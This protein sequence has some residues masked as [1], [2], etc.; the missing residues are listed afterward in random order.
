MPTNPPTQ[1]DPDQSVAE[2]QIREVF[3]KLNGSGAHA[4]YCERS[5]DGGCTCALKDEYVDEAVA[6]LKALLLDAQ[7]KTLEDFRLFVFG[8]HY[9]GTWDGRGATFNGMVDTELRE[10]A[11][12]L[13]NQKNQAQQH[14]TEGNPDSYTEYDDTGIDP[15]D[16]DLL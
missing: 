8:R 11:K 14:D 2:Q 12:H 3:G 6:Q 7:E 15:D 13:T 1:P 9:D 16:T 10:Y 5:A 4:C